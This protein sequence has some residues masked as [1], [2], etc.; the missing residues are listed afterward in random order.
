LLKEVLILALESEQNAVLVFLTL[1]KIH[2]LVE[3][4]QLEKALMEL[5]I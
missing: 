4:Q 1:E 3:I 2:Q 5:R